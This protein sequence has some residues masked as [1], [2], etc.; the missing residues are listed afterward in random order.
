MNVNEL[1]QLRDILPR[2][3]RTKIKDTT[4][5]SFSYIDQVLNGRRHSAIIINC[6]LA[7]LEELLL[8]EKSTSI[9]FQQILRL[10]KKV[11]QS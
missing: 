10:L 4:T 2:G 9:K 3:S 11:R 1:K 6:A 7:I 8:L 5:Y